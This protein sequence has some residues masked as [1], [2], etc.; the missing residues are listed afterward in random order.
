MQ[1][2]I[3]FEAMPF[4]HTVRIPDSIPDGIIVR[5]VLSFDDEEIKND[6]Q[7]NWKDLLGGM[8]NVGNDDDFARATDYGRE[9]TW[10]F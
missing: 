3:E 9:I 8:P 5:V 6:Q 10:D 2:Q 4:Q 1:Q 7:N